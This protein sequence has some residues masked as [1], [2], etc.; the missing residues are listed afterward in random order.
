MN[1]SENIISSFGKLKL[2]KS[3]VKELVN[4]FSLLNCIVHESSVMSHVLIKGTSNNN[5]KDSVETWNLLRGGILPGSLDKGSHNPLLEY[6]EEIE[7]EEGNAFKVCQR[8]KELAPK[9]ET[10]PHISLKAHFKAETFKKWNHM[11]NLV[12]I[13]L[14][15]HSDIIE[16]AFEYVLGMDPEDPDIPQ[17]EEKL[18]IVWKYTYSIIK[19]AQNSIF[20]YPN[21]KEILV[22]SLEI[23]KKSYTNKIK[24]IET[25]WKE[26]QEKKKK[27]DEEQKKIKEEVKKIEENKKEVAK[28]DK[29]VKSSASMKVAVSR[30]AKTS[31]RTNRRKLVNQVE[32]P[33]SKMKSKKEENKHGDDK[34]E[35][36]KEEEVGTEKVE[37]PPEIT[38]EELSNLNNQIYTDIYSMI[39]LKLEDEK[40]C[41]S[42]CERFGIQLN[43]M[44]IKAVLKQ[45]CRIIIKEKLKPL[46]NLKK[47]MEL[48]TATFDVNELK[49]PEIEI[50]KE[51]KNKAL[52]LLEFSPSLDLNSQ[53]LES[54]GEDLTI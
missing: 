34:E 42:L 46:I 50:I 13:C 38:D 36:H 28:G 2:Q 39:I 53:I 48:K 52:F 20:S 3:R 21:L 40:L 12:M 29:N 35:D 8:I 10:I 17:Y 16:D 30:G 27:D 47:P 26:N 33:K 49:A 7:K 18:K 45:I 31:K 15:Y 14:M 54:Q 43:N 1:I 22:E 6:L 25:K 41:R 51:I 5:T 19:W 44:N 4:W 24:S 32:I 23:A 9:N 11:I 37:Q